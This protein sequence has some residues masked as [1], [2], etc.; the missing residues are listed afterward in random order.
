MPQPIDQHQPTRQKMTD[1]NWKNP[2]PKSIA[3][4]KIRCS[5]VT[6][7]ENLGAPIQQPSRPAIIVPLPGKQKL[8]A[9]QM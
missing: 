5:V 1:K 7:A 3:K 8:R 2:T 9:K 6:M 4:A